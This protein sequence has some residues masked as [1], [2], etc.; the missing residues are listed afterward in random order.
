MSRWRKRPAYALSTRV[1]YTH[2]VWRPATI[3][4]SALRPRSA[5]GWPRSGRRVSVATLQVRGMSGRRTWK[6]PPGRLKSG[7]TCWHGGSAGMHAGKP[8]RADRPYKPRGPAATSPRHALEHRQRTEMPLPPPSM[9]SRT[10]NRPAA[11]GGAV[12]VAVPPVH[13][14]GWGSTAATLSRAGGGQGTRQMGA[15]Q[16]DQR[17]AGAT[18]HNRVVSGRRRERGRDGDGR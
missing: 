9:L 3:M 8:G 13:G 1:W 2:T 17:E 5:S 18:C 4:R 15:V 6:W 11:G 14:R 10:R 7:N 12:S 16:A